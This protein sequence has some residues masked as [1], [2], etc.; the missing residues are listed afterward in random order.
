MKKRKGISG[1]PYTKYD[2]ILECIR[3]PLFDHFVITRTEEH[4]S[5][6]E[7]LDRVYPK[8][9]QRKTEYAY[10]YSYQ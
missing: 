4:V 6:R 2:Y 7:K 10:L 8:L 1:V 3:I 9:R 5:I